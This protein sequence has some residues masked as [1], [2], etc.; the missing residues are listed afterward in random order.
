MYLLNKKLKIITL[1]LLI[2]LIIIFSIIHKNCNFSRVINVIANY[3]L[4]YAYYSCKKQTNY[5]IKNYI[6]RKISNTYFEKIIREFNQGQIKRS[7]T[8]LNKKSLNNVNFEKKSVPKRILGIKNNIEPFLKEKNKFNKNNEDTTWL[9]SHGGYKNKKYIQSKNSINVNNINNLSLEWVYDSS[10]NINLKY[11]DN[12]EANPIFD[13]GII[14][15]LTGD[16]TLTALNAINGNLI[17]KKQS[18]LTPA[19]RGFLLNKEKDGSYIYINIGEAIA[20]IYSSNGNLDKRF[21]KNGILYSVNSPTPP[22]IYKNN[23]YIITATKVLVY[24]KISGEFLEQIKI[25]PENKEFN[26]GGVVWGGNAFDKDKGYLYLVSG[27][28]RPALIGI[29]RIGKNEN[30]NSLIAIDLNQSKIIWTFQDVFHDLWDFDISSPP[31]ITDLKINNKYLEVVIISTKT[32]NTYI[33]ERNTGKSFFDL[34]FKKTSPSNI[35]GEKAFSYQRNNLL[36]EK[37]IDIEYNEKNFN[38]LSQE[39]Q[40][41]IKKIFNESS[42]GWFPPP[43][44]GKKTIIFGLHGGATWMG[45]AYDPFNQIIYTPVV[46]IPW[47]LKVEGKTLENNFPKKIKNLNKIY[48]EKCSSCHGKY[49]NGNFDP[50]SKKNVEILK[51]YIPS[52]I[53]HSLSLDKNNFND[54]YNLEKINL[55]HKNIKITEAELVKIK[56][57]FIQLDKYL[58]DNNKIFLRYYWYKFLDEMNYP[59]SNPPGVK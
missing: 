21:G 31:V 15:S 9:R 26:R 40:K 34:E 18:L 16:R 2:F 13:N 41:Y 11:H 12:V 1:I 51:D 49:R 29:D 8:F 37:L 38:N 20:K 54:L 59:A 55:I 14:Y 42:T 24:N 56:K 27:N 39:K 44:I 36:P 22:V 5:K 33:L 50:E 30:A 4:N 47:I 28:P 32:G 35:P 52:L 45:S 46:N 53:G 58:L 10:K 48:L 3:N 43:E 6:K 57:L 25:H 23:L 19:R 7:Y 17:W